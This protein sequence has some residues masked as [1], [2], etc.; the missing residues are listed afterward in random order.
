ML[1]FVLNTIAHKYLH[2]LIYGMIVIDA[3]NSKQN[4]QLD[5]FHFDLL[6]NHDSHRADYNNLIEGLFI[7]ASHHSVGVQFADLVAGAVY[8]KCSKR[9][10]IFYN[11][12][13]NNVRRNS[14]G[15]AEGFG[16]VAV[17]N[18]SC[19]IEN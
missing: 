10:S 6:N 16:V 4:K 18:G 9:D 3:R 12:I 14:Q 1:V 2:N 8:R 11:M 5:D 17:P 19:I 13:R 7:A 15:K